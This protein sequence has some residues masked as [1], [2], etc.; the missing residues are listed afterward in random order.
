[1]MLTSC[2]GA[3]FFGSFTLPKTN[4]L[5]RMVEIR[6]FPF[7]MAYFQGAMLVSGKV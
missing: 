1:M 2:S 5:K 6:S 7:G 4:H 3:A